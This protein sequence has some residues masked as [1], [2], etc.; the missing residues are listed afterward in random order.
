[1]SDNRHNLKPA[2]LEA[3]EREPYFSSELICTYKDH[4]GDDDA[5]LEAMLVSTQ[6]AEMAEDLEKYKRSRK[7]R[8]DFM[9]SHKH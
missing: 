4:M 1:M 8:L 3:L 6:D 2:E 9:M 7:P 5:I